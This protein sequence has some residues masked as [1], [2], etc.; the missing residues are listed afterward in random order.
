MYAN[1]EIYEVM[2]SFEKALKDAPVYVGGT[3]DRCEMEEIPQPDG[4]ISKRFTRNNYYNNGNVNALFLLFLH[5]YA[6][7]KCEGRMEAA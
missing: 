1:G 6:A 4:L 3:V 7:G 5:G 2:K